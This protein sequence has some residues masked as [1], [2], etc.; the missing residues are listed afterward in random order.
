MEERRY[1]WK[2]FIKSLSFLFL[3]LACDPCK[4]DEIYSLPEGDIYFTAMP[5]N[6]N[7]PSIVQIDINQSN[8]KEIIKNGKLYSA[9]SKDNKLVFVRD[10]ATGSQDIILSNI[11][12]SNQRII[13]GSFH[14]YSRDFAV[15]SSNGSLIA[16]GANGNELWIVKNETIYLKISSNFCKGTLPSFS[17]DGT[18]IAFF[19]GKDL[20][21]SPQSI[22][23]YYVNS[24]QPKTLCKKI[25]PGTIV[26]LYGEPLPTWSNDNV[27]V[28]CCVETTEKADIIYST[29]FEGSFEKTWE[30][31]FVGCVEALPSS[32]ENIFYTIGR[33]GSIWIVNFNELTKRFQFVSL[34]SGYSYNLFPEINEEKKLILYTRFYRD[35]LNQFGG[36]LEI[37]NISDNKAKPIIIGS[38]VFRAFWNKFKG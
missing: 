14:W 3:L 25:L 9:P 4:Y 24:E 11:D 37:L 19:E 10:Y 17:P 22:V 16:I 1:Y 13:A 35:E 30:V 34:S 8:P 31:E 2:T 38:N 15:L 21:T 23:I 29:S 20:Y 5:V 32:R 28:Y 6:S 18:K 26:E 27:F 36:T 33:D 12:G 7:E